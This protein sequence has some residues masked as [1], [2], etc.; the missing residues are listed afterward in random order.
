MPRSTRREL[1]TAR[2]R[3]SCGRVLRG[4]M[5]RTRSM[6]K[7]IMSDPVKVILGQVVIKDFNMFSIKQD[8]VFPE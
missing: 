6:M 3:R 8:H 2:R 5:R 7:Q 1:T 4:T